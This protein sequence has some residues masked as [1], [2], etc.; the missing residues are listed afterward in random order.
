MAE[1]SILSN[2]V[3]CRISFHDRLNN[4]AAI[5]TSGQPLRVEY[6]DGSDQFATLDNIRPEQEGQPLVSTFLADLNTH[7]VGICEFELVADNDVTPE[8]SAELRV[9]VTVAIMPATASGAGFSLGTGVDKPATPEN[10]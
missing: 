4:V 3:D 7:A 10:P 8:G 5:D 2:Y 6:K 9:P 1:A